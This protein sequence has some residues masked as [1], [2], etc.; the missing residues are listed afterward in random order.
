MYEKLPN[1]VRNWGKKSKN[2]LI[3]NLLN[4]MKKQE[5]KIK[6]NYNVESFS[7]K[8]YIEKELKYKYVSK[9]DL[10]IQ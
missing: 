4:L 5:E 9:K 8:I 6:N 7:L 10:L 1:S 3:K 2:Q